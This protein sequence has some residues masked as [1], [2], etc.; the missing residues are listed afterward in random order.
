MTRYSE[1]HPDVQRLKRQIAEEEARQRKEVSGPPVTPSDDP[2][3]AA[4]T[5]KQPRAPAPVQHFNPVLQSQLNVVEEEIAKHKQE[6]ERLS[7]L[8]SKYQGKLE[9]IPVNEQQITALVRDYEISKTHY[10]QLLEKQLSAETATQLEIRQKGERFSIL[11]PAQPAQRP[12]KPNRILIDLA[13]TVCGLG[14][15]LGLAVLT[16]LLGLSITTAEQITATS[17]LP[18]LEII[19]VIETRAG[20]AIRRRR[21]ILSAVCASVAFLVAAVGFLIYRYHGEIF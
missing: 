20:R 15:G 17:G 12:S 3:P 2:A 6:K 8:V 11:D 1:Y 21:F 4:A 19:P 5:K 9:A 18:V 13:G 10:Q 16:E 14:L 7:A